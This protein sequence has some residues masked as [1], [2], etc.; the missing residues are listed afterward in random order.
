MVA[1]HLLPPNIDHNIDHNNKTDLTMQPYSAIEKQQLL[2]LARESIRHG[3]TYGTQLTVP[4]ENYYYH[5]K[6]PKATFVTLKIDGLL[7]GCIGNIQPKETLLE[8]VAQNAYKAAFSDPRFGQLKEDEFPHLQIEISILSD[9][10]PITFSSE[11]NLL[12]QIK[13]SRDGL[14]LTA[15][16]HS[17]TFLP[18]VWEQ[19]P[20]PTT[21][22]QHLK[23]KAG[24]DIHHWPKDMSIERYTTFSFSN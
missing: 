6:E 4:M 20:E 3:L 16:E 12:E 21:F 19:L 14:L 2:S 24:L 11:S 9:L 10:E 1:G 22:M 17:A 5:L 18:S 23:A 7:R 15:G 8:S 13:P